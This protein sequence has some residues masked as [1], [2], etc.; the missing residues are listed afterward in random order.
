[1]YTNYTTDLIKENCPE[2]MTPD[3]CALREYVN[4]GNDLFHVSVNE[5]HLVV[6]GGV[7][8]LIRL[9]NKMHKICEKCKADNKQNT[10]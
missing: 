1:M 2:G 6:D 10:K 8:A 7:L 9:Y 3:N 4:S 5:N